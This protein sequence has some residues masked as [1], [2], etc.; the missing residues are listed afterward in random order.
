MLGVGTKTLGARRVN[1]ARDKR[2][3][4]NRPG[5]SESGK[6][7]RM[8]AYK[9]IVK[10]TTFQFPAAYRFSTVEGRP[11]LWADSGL[12]ACLGLKEDLSPGV[13]KENLRGKR[14]NT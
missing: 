12:P 8:K 1:E 7:G 2:L 9:Y 5:V 11:S 4:L 6:A 3:T 13:E 10:V 14:I